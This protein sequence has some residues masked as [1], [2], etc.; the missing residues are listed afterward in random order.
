[1]V[2]AAWSAQQGLC[3]LCT[4]ALH[5]E[6]GRGCHVDHDHETGRFRGLLCGNCNTALGTLGDNVEGLSRALA[7]VKG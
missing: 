3:A 7:Y 4:K 1:M 5:R 2:E 6:S